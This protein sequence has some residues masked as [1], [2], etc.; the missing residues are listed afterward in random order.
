ME[1][2]A[3]Q[4][5][6]ARW[7][8]G[9]QRF[10]GVLA[11]CW[12]AGL[13]VALAGILAGKLH[14]LEVAPWIWGVASLGIGLAVAVLWVVLTQRGPIDAAI[15]IDRRFGLKERI[16][17]ALAMSPDERES[18][19]GRAL[20]EDAIRRADRIDVDEHFGVRPDKRLLLPLVPGLAALVVALFVSPLVVENPAE[21][22]TDPALSK[23]AVDKAQAA[24][25]E[26]LERQRKEAEKQGLK[27][28][29][30]LFE[31]LQKEAQ[32]L[33]EK[34]QGDKKKALVQLNDLAK[35]IDK[36][37][38]ELGGA[39]EVKNQL[40]Q[41]SK[42]DKTGP[43]DKFAKAVRK[44]DFQQAMKELEKL[45]QDLENGALSEEQK[46]ELKSQIDEMKD[47]LDK[48][49][50]AHE[51]AKQ[52]LQEQIDKAKKSGNAA[53]ASKLE[54][55]LEKLV[56]QGP[57]MDKL[58]D[59]AEKLGQCSKCMKDGQM[60]DAAGQLKQLQQD[61]DGLAQQL[62]QMEMLD[63][64]KEQLQMARDQMTC[65]K[66]KG[67][68]CAEC[69]G[70][71]GEGDKPGGDGLGKGRGK[72]FRPEKETDTK[73]YDTTTPQNVGKGSASI[74][75]MVDGPNIKGEVGQRIEQELEAAQSA[76]S[77][78]ITS[79]RLPRKHRQEVQE[80][81]DQIQGSKPK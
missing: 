50:Q 66:C 59:I 10:L 21:A 67:Q 37:R 42:L 64:A 55:Q 41:L 25:S 22:N 74:V 11:W 47:K 29:E 80:Y 17:S 36:K 12:F 40:R 2:I 19:A 18:E 13:F 54:E 9:L 38:E 49:G 78:P 31:K 44:G 20:L 15:E 75:D 6:R 51:K 56:Q 60:K 16:S 5:R 46:A 39:E 8:L 27:D 72:G 1:T 43:G 35:E 34:T 48:M 62:D 23:K 63:E 57:Q 68:G 28:A 53:E 4:V 61:L 45:K 79:Q 3:K 32:D 76:E 58:K 7:R 70:G 69:Q 26:K 14:W 71:E 33:S 30:R 77:D 73:F 24:L 65:P 52:D 81:F